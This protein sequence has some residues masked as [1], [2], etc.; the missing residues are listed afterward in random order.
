MRKLLRQGIVGLSAAASL[1][2][3]PTAATPA[4]AAPSAIPS[5]MTWT[6]LA[7]GTANGTVRV[8][9]DSGTDPYYGDTPA[10]ATLPLLCLRVTG[11]GVPSGITPDFYAGWARGTVA[12]TPPVQGRSLTSRSVA[13]NLC[14]QYYGTG[15]RM[16][17]FHDGRYGSNLESSGGWSFWAHGYLPKDTRFWAAINDQPANPWN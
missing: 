4:Q 2:L 16:A 7:E 10:T 6:V 12:A 14:T 3:L 1:A 17:E 9:A 13:D 8:G 15:W 5:G 11:S